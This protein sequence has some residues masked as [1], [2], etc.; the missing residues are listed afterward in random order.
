MVRLVPTH[1]LYPRPKNLMEMARL[2]RT[3]GAE[4]NHLRA[5]Q[6]RRVP[7]AMNM[8]VD[9]IEKIASSGVLSDVHG[10]Q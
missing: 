7:S 10:L 3:L 6:G 2:I 8:R 4:I 1:I 9:L 5:D